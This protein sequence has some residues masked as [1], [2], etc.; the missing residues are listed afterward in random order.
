MYH[1]RQMQRKVNTCK[2]YIY[3]W[4]FSER[5]VTT[6]RG[7]GVD[8]KGQ[9][10]CVHIQDF[11]PHIYIETDAPVNLQNLK[12]TICERENLYNIHAGRQNFYKVFFQTKN[13]TNAFIRDSELDR[14]TH[15]QNAPT[16][17]QFLT[18]RNLHQVGWV[19]FIGVEIAED[20]LCDKNY[21]CLWTDIGPCSGPFVPPLVCAFDCEVYSTTR[22]AMPCDKPG[23][24][25]FQISAVFSDGDAFLISLEGSDYDD[26]VIQCETE[27]KLLETFITLIREKKPM[28]LTGY[29]ILGFDIEYIIKR[30]TRL[31]LL[32]NLFNMGYGSSPGELRTAKWSSDALGVQEFVYIDWEGIVIL[33]LL[34]IVK[35]D[36]KFSNYKLETVARAFMGYGK[37][38]VGFKEIM[39]AYETKLMSRVGHYCVKDSKLCLDLLEKM[40]TWIGL[41]EMGN[42]CNVQPMTLYLQGQQVRIYSQVYKYCHHNNIVVN[43]NAYKTPSGLKYSGAYV[44]EPVKGV[45]TNVVPFD[46]SSLYPSIIITENICYSTI[47]GKHIDDSKCNVF[48]WEDHIGCQHDPKVIKYNKISSD[49]DSLDATI[50]TLMTQRDALKSKAQKEVVQKQINLKREAQKPLRKTRLDLKLQDSIVICAKNRYKFLKATEKVGVIPTIIKNLLESRKII[51]GR[52]KKETD[53]VLKTILDKQQLAYKVSANSMYGAMGVRSGYLPYMPGAMCVTYCGREAIKK[54]LKIIEKKFNGSVIYVDTDSN[55]VQ[56][57]NIAEEKLWSHA[58]QVSKKVSS[59]FP[60]TMSLEFEEKIYRKFVL[61]GKKRYVYT[62]R[63]ETGTHSK[64][65]YKGVVVARRD[66]AK[67]TRDLYAKCVHNIMDNADVSDVAISIINFLSVMWA[68]PSDDF[69]ITKGVGDAEGEYDYE[70]GKLGNYKV[71]GLALDY[72]TREKQLAGRSEQ[73]W[74]NSQLPGH[75]QLVKKMLKRGIPIAKGSR[76][77][78]II[79]DNGKTKL[80]ERMEDL[81]YFNENKWRFKLD[82]SYYITSMINPIDQLLETV[83]NKP[84]FSQLA[85]ALEAKRK[86]LKQLGDRFRPKLV[87]IRNNRAV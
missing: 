10:V 79:I 38:P 51:K 81:D 30:C 9:R 58:L 48:E 69:V 59:H 27:A 67:V 3:Q 25:I 57:P 21:D 18:Q 36:Y 71:K 74:Y 42:V 64:I 20:N 61:L 5:Y 77:E 24:E 7:Y 12:F 35:R 28:I 17:L 47:A 55:Y 14:W 15:E 11:Q 49:I 53:S 80:G 63:D 52:L 8:Q 37:D 32:E 13:G 40:A 56:F 33:D 75:M 22:N 82:K 72:A 46:F 84:L 2:A 26:D 87:F 31:F 6:I 68:L 85:A 29:N 66:N 45:Y 60:E 86:C 50:R 44:M 19:E 54:S 41:V 73:D 76:I 4:C 65:G 83:Y 43:T 39:R 78:I 62:E 23:D 16:L 1:H 70:S 34:P